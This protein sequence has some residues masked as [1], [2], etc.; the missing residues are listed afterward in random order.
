VGSV[1][2]TDEA[3]AI[4]VWL[5]PYPNPEGNLHRWRTSISGVKGWQLTHRPDMGYAR[6]LG[7]IDATL[8]QMWGTLPK[9]A[10]EA[11]SATYARLGLQSPSQRK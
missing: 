4:R 11:L 9:G 7:A 1:R 8:G 5:A 6:A 10:Q 3:G 2:C